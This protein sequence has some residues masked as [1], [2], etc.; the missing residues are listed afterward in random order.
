MDYLR[1]K[2]VALELLQTLS[3]LMIDLNEVSSKVA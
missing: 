2:K 3:T 1:S